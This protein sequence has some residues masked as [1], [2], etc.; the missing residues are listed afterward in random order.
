MNPRLRWILLIPAVVASWYVIV[1]GFGTY[2][3]RLTSDCSSAP[4]LPQ[5]TSFWYVVQTSFL[6][7][8]AA[9]VSAV[10]VVLVAYA[11]APTKKLSVARICFGVGAA[12][13]A[14]A[15]T[16]LGLLGQFQLVIAAAFAIVAGALT[17]ASVTRTTEAVAN[18]RG[19]A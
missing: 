1:S 19:K 9:A 10:T 13:A 7:I 18:E 12:I 6:P 8:L 16:F 14:I 3:Q 15:G 5:C 4:D 17:I 2:Y 11:V